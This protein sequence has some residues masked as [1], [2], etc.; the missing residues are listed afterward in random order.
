MVSRQP[1]RVAVIG[2]G[3]I[4]LETALRLQQQGLDVQVYER[5][6]VAEHVRQWGHV[7]MFSPFG[8]NVTQAGIRAIREQNPQHTFPDS[9]QLITGQQFVECYLEP[10]ATTHWL[11]QRIHTQTEVVQIGRGLYLKED[12]PGSRQ[13]ANSRFRL[14]LRHNQQERVEEADVVVDCSGTYRHHRWLGEGGIP[15]V[16]ELAA[17]PH[18]RYHLEDL[19]GQRSGHYRGRSVLVVGS[20]YSAATAICELAQLAEQDAA[21]WT[22]WLIR[23]DGPP[24]RRFPNDPLSERDRLA[25]L[26]NRL[27][28]RGEGNIEL[29]SQAHVQSVEFLAQDRGFRVHARVQGT[30][31][32]WEVER[33]LAHVGYSPDC[34]LYQELQVHECYATLGPMRLAATL[35]QHSGDCLS[36]PSTGPETLRNP[37]PNFFILGAKSFGRQ[38]AF[39]LQAGFTQIEALLTLLRQ[40]GLLHRP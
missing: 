33:I 11:R 7:T 12:L 39:L 32:T 3:P 20:G 40:D 28:A 16:G 14:L 6:R 35:I 13:R 9:K 38:S 34:S 31:R 25:Q 18:I 5:G 36:L 4:G 26:A 37:E 1:V 27:A 21:T 10:L 22:V 2:A 29:V 19:L 30:M 23:R 15:A 24:I 17:E 8:M